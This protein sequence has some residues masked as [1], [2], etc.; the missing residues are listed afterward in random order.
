MR[1][2][3]ITVF[4]LLALAGFVFA[5]DA[6]ITSVSTDAVVNQN[7]TVQV[8]L[9]AEIEFSAAVRTIQI[10]LG[11]GAKDIVLSGWAYQK[12]DVGGV[13]C[14][15]VTN[16]AGF[17]GRQSFAC[18]YTLPCA[19]T[20]NSAGQSFRLYAP[21]T[22]WEY[23]IKSMT[24]KVAFPA[25]VSAVPEWNSGYFE[26]IIDNYL[27]IT[28]DG[29][30]VTAASI[31]ALKDHETLRMDLQ[32]PAGTF[33]LGGQPG[34]TFTAD[35]IAFFAFF[36]LAPL[37]WFFFLRYRLLLPRQQQTAGT[38]STAGEVP[39]QLYGCPADAGGMLAHWGN[40]GYITIE[41]GRRG[42]ILICKRMEM[43]NER[44][45]AER[46][47]FRALF[48]SGEV[49]DAGSQRFRAA[50]AQLELSL[51]KS[52]QRRLFSPQ[53]GSPRLLK[54][55]GLA[56]GL[57]FS[58]MIFDTLLPVFGARTF[59]LIFLTLLGGGLHF[60]LQNGISRILSRRRRLPLLLAAGAAAALCLLG[61]LA[62][63]APLL[64]LDL[65]LQVFCALTTLFGGKRTTAG[66]ERARRL[67]GLRRFLRR[68]DSGTLQR[69]IYQD[70][71][72]FYRMLPFAEELGVASSFLRHIGRLAPESCGWLVD[73]GQSV[74]TPEEF[75]RLYSEMLAVVRGERYRPTPAVPQRRKPVRRP[76]QPPAAAAAPQRAQRPH[77]RA[78]YDSEEY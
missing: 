55:L 14:L 9:N 6:E 10:P 15:T 19:V 62:G 67:L 54:C 20:T 41:R 12:T 5:A 47:F 35:I 56:A 8:T 18:T 60:L 11:A 65:L 13:T 29:P 21:Q 63:K 51:Q 44:T 43:G 30:T 34:K 53:S 2:I 61:G 42:R 40:L 23:A 58:L 38:D 37:Y 59:F 36:L 16:E 33:S 70:P 31:T 1:R 69:L 66:Q 57:A 49:C 73:A 39:C 32:F 3:W 4:C 17:T 28:V 72:Y 64:L 75:Y 46:K 24:L 26:D 50:A 25:D 22:G 68:A 74:R 78:E 27:N 76:P 71:Q 48:R 77:R 45:A 52:W 7:G